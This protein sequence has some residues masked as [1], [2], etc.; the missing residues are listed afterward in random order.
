MS[1][2]GCLMKIPDNLNERTVK[3]IANINWQ[4]K[5]EDFFKAV[6]SFVHQCLG[7]KC[8]L[9]VEIT[10]IE[11]GRTVAFM[12][13]GEPQDNVSYE[14]NGTPCENVVSSDYCFCPRDIQ[15]SFPN[16]EMLADIDAESYAGIPLR[17][18]AG[19]VLG[20]IAIMDT[21]ALAHKSAI[22]TFLRILSFGVGSVLEKHLD[23]AKIA[24]GKAELKRLKDAVATQ[25]QRME[26]SQRELNEVEAR[27][28]RESADKLRE[29][30]E[31]YALAIAGS[32]DGIWDWDFL[33]NE[34]FYSERFGDILGYDSP[35][36]PKQSEAYYDMLHPDDAPVV[37]AA[38]VNHIKKISDYNL[39]YRV[40]HKKGHYVWIH[41][42]GQAIWD[43]SGKA[44]RMAGSISD[45]SERVAMEAKLRESEERYALAVAGSRDAIWDW[46]IVTGEVVHAP[47]LREILGYNDLE[48]HDKIE[49]FQDALHPDDL[50]RVNAAIDAHIKKAG[51]Y[52]LEFRMRHKQGHYVWLYAKGQAIWN[53]AGE[54]VRMAGSN[55]DISHRVNMETRLRESEGRHALAVAASHG[56]MWDWNILTGDMV[57]SDRY[58]EIV[59]YSEDELPDS[60][61]S[62]HL[63]TDSE[64]YKE[65]A[66]LM[67]EH[68]AKKADYDIEHRLKTKTGDYIWVHSK[69]QAIWD[70]SGEPVRM[71]GW[72]TDITKR[73]M[74]EDK[75]R[76]SEERHALAV[77][78]SKDSIYDWNILTGDVI[79]GHRFK[80][81]L[82]YVDAEFPDKFESFNAALHPDDAERVQASVHR[83]L[84]NDGKSYD[85]RFRM[86]H[87][88]GHYIWIHA[89][90]QA[91]W[92][93]AGEPV[94][95]AGSNSDISD[96]IERE[97]ALKMA[98]EEAEKANRSK[99]EFLAAMSHELR[100]PLNAIIGFSDIIAFDRL[101]R[102]GDKKYGEYAHDINSSAGYLLSLINDLLDMST[103]DAGRMEINKSKMSVNDLLS[104]CH[105]IVK[106]QASDS[107]ITMKL[108]IPAI[109]QTIFADTRALQQ[110][111]LNLAQNS[112]KN[113]PDGGS[114]MLS[115]LLRQSH[116]EIVVEDTGKGI[117]K[118]K[119][120]KLTEAFVKGH[121]DPM[122]ATEGW[123][124][125][126]A[127]SK[128][129]IDLHDGDLAIESELGKGTKVT[130]KIPMSA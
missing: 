127:I 66:A 101:K 88:L 97:I 121:N 61:E 123:G 50:E 84:S 90:G 67:K 44:M 6:A 103:I 69:G 114:V 47:R 12:M 93:D 95:M 15:Q 99:S 51:E 53:D 118:E 49:S 13:D 21:D 32:N 48:F 129:L 30:E 59:G 26:K 74:T 68:F 19:E 28:R 89:K 83:H 8:V 117:A 54:P 96:Q 42:R 87:K 58:R 122:V 105:N 62:M 2:G 45:I 10:A 3:F 1:P 46:N 52:N 23:E 76:L 91:I 20:L 17:D 73:K 29:S 16:D 56:G 22:E 33:T 71:V 18:S 41:A 78:G 102:G 128:A 107:K 113:T 82:G 63:I 108:Q 40:R 14:L 4:L 57:F 24:E 70:D 119:I 115:A 31:R 81:M 124:L 77:E 36:I 126:L 75:L 38:M 112:L 60:A 72:A 79:Y 98:K 130:V 25:E 100:T 94:R 34:V 92:N 85:E 64:T 37:R 65:C 9:I 116:I 125:G 43:E 35:L 11:L 39:E 120:P 27:I 106:G 86:R 80:E 111:V 110:V 109:D 55:S 7:V 104:E 5:D